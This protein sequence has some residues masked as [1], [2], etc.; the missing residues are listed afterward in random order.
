MQNIVNVKYVISSGFEIIGL[1]LPGPHHYNNNLRER[2]RV[3][4]THANRERGRER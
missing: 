1:W 4:H 3:R 2:E